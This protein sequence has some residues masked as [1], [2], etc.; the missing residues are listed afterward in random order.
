M[1]EGA[2]G[3]ALN[4]VSA[5]RPLMEPL[6]P[7]TVQLGSI[8]VVEEIP[9]SCQEAKNVNFQGISHFKGRE[10]IPKYP[11]VPLYGMQKF[12]RRL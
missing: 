6:P 8:R 1:G 9:S 10:S 12:L 7:V 2:S 3:R 5:H 4:A 11:C